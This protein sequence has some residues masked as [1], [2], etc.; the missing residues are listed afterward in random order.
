MSELVV[1]GSINVDFVARVARLP[2]PG[3]TVAGG[4]FERH[5]GGKGANQA[6]AA[7]RLG[8]TVA[9]VGAVGSDELGQ[10]SLA[11]LRREG[12]DVSGVRR[13]LDST[14][15]A[16]VIVVDEAGQNQIAVASAANLLVDGPMVRAALAGWK[17]SAG[18]GVLLEVFEVGDEALVAGARFARERGLVLIV[19]PA[20]ARALPAPLVEAH[21]IVVANEV[22]AAALS[23][24]DD[25]ATAARGIT[26]RTGAP[27]IV[28]M[29][30]EG[31]LIAAGQTVTHVAAP[32]VEVMDTTGAGD[33]FVGAFAAE[34]S[35]GVDV[36]EAVRFAVAA[37]SVSVTKPG[38]RGGMPDRA[39]VEHSLMTS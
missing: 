26:G 2:R 39:L 35:R 32:T 13:L 33:A 4:A 23:G 28:T 11:D 19:N 24:G 38:A 18:R 10:A 1:V 7:A 37:A 22:E 6:V 34:L 5:F 3:E 27:A 25:P 21:A 29:G 20:P 9:L 14:T 30:A 36:E 16:A 12:V 8:A 31:A 17:P 15:G